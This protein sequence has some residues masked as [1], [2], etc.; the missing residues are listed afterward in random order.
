V[1]GES[2]GKDEVL[3]DGGTNANACC[4]YSGEIDWT[5]LKAA[6]SL[7]QDAVLWLLLNLG[8]YKNFVKGGE[9]TTLS[10]AKPLGPC[11]CSSCIAGKWS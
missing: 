7:G 1:S 5:V 6:S 4:K 2:I 11:W 10:C 8:A 9:F 3:M